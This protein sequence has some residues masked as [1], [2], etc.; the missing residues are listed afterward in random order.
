MKN[1]FKILKDIHKIDGKYLFTSALLSISKTLESLFLAILP[2]VLISILKNGND[3]LKIAILFAAVWTLL[4]F[5]S[6]YLETYNNK[7]GRKIN[8]VYKNKFAL[9]TIRL[10]Y[11]MVE[12]VNTNVLKRE[13]EQAL[14]N[15][16]IL[17]GI[18]DNIE[19]FAKSLLFF[20]SA[21]LILNTSSYYLIPIYLIILSPIIILSIKRG[22]IE[23][24]YAPKSAPI[25][26][27]VIYFISE[28]IM[29]FHQM[30]F[31]VYNTNKLMR[32]NIDALTIDERVLVL[33]K[34]TKTFKYD[35]AISLLR[36][37]NTIILLLTAYFMSSKQT[38]DVELFTLIVMLIPRVVDSLTD[39]IVSGSEL[40]ELVSE[41]KPVET[42]LNLDSENRLKSGNSSA[43][44]FDT[45]EFKNVS[46]TYP[47]N[48]NQTLK[49]VSFI[50][51]RNERISIV[52]PNLS[53]KSTIVKLI[54]RFYLPDSG[55][56][57]LNGININ[58]IQ[59][60]AYLN[61]IS[62][63][64]QDF[65]FFPFT[66]GENISLEKDYDDKKILNY[67]DEV[68]LKD[69]IVSLKNG[70]DTHLNKALYDDATS[71]SGGQYQKLAMVRAMNKESEIMI[72]DEPTSA[73]DPIAESQI[74]EKFD[75]ITQNKTVLFI[76]HRMSTCGFS[77]KVL[78]L[79]MG[80]VKG[81][82]PHEEL[83]KENELYNEL[84]YAQAKYFKDIKNKNLQE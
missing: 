63:I 43:L 1:I 29:P 34:T 45:L 19:K 44:K 68:G 54:C 46:F 26:W 42:F 71:F 17:S 72:F 48:T 50:I 76:T 58:D 66:I 77:D 3:S 10:P 70:L 28:A 39:M 51:H 40:K 32:K 41:F 22:K 4:H 8:T 60:D 27:R 15:M 7:I 52:G 38:F 35:E 64:F 75:E 23:G 62:T 73:L 5:I 21:I 30:D 11:H 13:A 82:C 79:E 80:E 6:Q 18:L 20:I 25:S 9:K 83:L 67:I 55:E 24:E 57:L 31:R 65:S 37:L 84:Y 47:G 81:F 16:S 74:I 33:E 36:G 2:V 61:L 12:D 69:K 49:N 59:K 14:F 56:I 78:L 53:G